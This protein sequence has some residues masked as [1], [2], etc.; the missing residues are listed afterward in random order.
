MTY[1]ERAFATTETQI[2][3]LESG[4]S[5]GTVGQGDK[6]WSLGREIEEEEEEVVVVGVV[7]VLV[8][9][10]T[11]VSEGEDF[12]KRPAAGRAGIIKGKR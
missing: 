10:G 9:D 8:A 7:L 2:E 1:P 4:V 11:R 12:P 6:A 3:H 5:K